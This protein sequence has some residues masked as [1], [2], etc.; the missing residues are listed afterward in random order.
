MRGFFVQTAFF[1]IC[2][3]GAF[4]VVLRYLQ[5]AVP[6]WFWRFYSAPGRIFNCNEKEDNGRMAR[7]CP[8][9]EF[10]LFSENLVV[11]RAAVKQLRHWVE[12]MRLRAQENTTP[13]AIRRRQKKRSRSC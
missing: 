9:N 11:N 10:F 3:S 12:R 6:L 1:L 4:S 8:D 2:H 7:K 5:E 13:T